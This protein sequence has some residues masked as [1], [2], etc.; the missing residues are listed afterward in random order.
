M[1]IEV[2]RATFFSALPVSLIAYLVIS[3][4]I[5]SNRLGRF[6]DNK[7]LKAAMKDMSKKHKDE[8]KTKT[9][10]KGSSHLLVNKW[11]YFGG[12]FYGLMALITYAVIEIREIIGFLINL[13][14]L[15]WS[16]VLSSVSIKMLVDLL[17]AA[18]KN[19]I[20]AF[21]W[22]K[23]WR[24]EIDMEN[25]WFWLIGAYVGYLLGARLA[26][27]YPMR[28]TLKKLFASNSQ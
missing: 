18:I 16:E 25:G 11:L 12:G 14:D 9:D 3:H 23:Y 1:Y 22:F 2:L 17:V 20:D 4:A 28:F 5:L 24:G 21:V 10:M 15:N 13:F 19:L 27:K 6:S 7:S 26:E 8:K